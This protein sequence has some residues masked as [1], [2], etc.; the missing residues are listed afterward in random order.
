MKLK[1]LLFF[2]VSIFIVSG[3]FAQS[4]QKLKE[5]SRNPVW[6]EMMEDSSVN[7]F[8][9]EKAFNEFWSI[10]PIPEEENKMIGERHENEKKKSHFLPFKS[11]KEK[12]KEESEKYTFQYK[13]FKHWQMLVLPYVQEDGR[14]LSQ[15]ERIQIWKEV[16]QSK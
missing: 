11:K 16:Q 4:P 9:A 10:R 2:F 3:I 1:T 6:I 7:Y 13:K 14:I 12:M 5:Y 15:E 8:E